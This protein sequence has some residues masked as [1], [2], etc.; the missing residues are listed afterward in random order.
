MT[1]GQKK[2]TSHCGWTSRTSVEVSAS[3][4][5]R[6]HVVKTRV[7]LAKASTNLKMPRE[8]LSHVQ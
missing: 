6:K 7:T 2:T 4:A 3:I 8:R 1:P 5:N